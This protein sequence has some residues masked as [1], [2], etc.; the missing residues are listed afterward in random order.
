M[1]DL[2]N[3]T[4]RL[5]ISKANTT[6]VVAVGI[7]AFVTAFS[8]V[9]SRSLLARQSYQNRVI[10]AREQARDQLQLNIEAV[11]SLKTAYNE[12]VARPENVLGGSSNGT[13]DRDGD[14]ARIILD[15]LPSKY[16][17][18]AL[19]SS[20]E[21][22]LSDKNYKIVSITGTD[23]EA[24]QNGGISNVEGAGAV[25][26]EATATET[27]GA[28]GS[29]V[30]FTGSATAMPFT[31]EAEGSYGKLVGLLGIFR[32]S[33]RPIHISSLTFTA[34]DNQNNTKLSVTGTSYFQAEKSLTI[35]DEVVQ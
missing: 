31:I 1:A 34:G 27:E 11:N 32:N 14:N 10:E 7:A 6:I 25:I 26:D 24:N 28:T 15:A 33:I 8:L 19:A 12:F 29:Q 13:S 16:D 30:T 22:I 18:P 9:A 21:K 17:Y 2:Q 4:K 20:L 5:Q 23:D 35:T 3:T